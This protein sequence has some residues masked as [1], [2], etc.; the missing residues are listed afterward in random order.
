VDVNSCVNITSGGTYDLNGSLSGAPNDASE[1]TGVSNACIKIAANSV[2]LDCHGY[3]ISLGGTDSV[4]I[5]IN[6]SRSGIT[7]RN[8][9]NITGFEVGIQAEDVD[10]STFYNNVISS[11]SVYGV[12][13]LYGNN[14]NF[15]LNTLDNTGLVGFGL[16]NVSNSHIEDNVVTDSGHGFSVSTVTG[17][18]FTGNNVSTDGNGFFIGIDSDGNTFSFNRIFGGGNSG[19]VIVTS[20]TGNTFTS[21]DVIGNTNWG[22]TAGSQSSGNT[23]IDNYVFNNGLE[24][25]SMTGSSGGNTFIVNNITSNDEDGME[26]RSGSGS[27]DFLVNYIYGNGGDGVDLGS[28][29]NNSFT[30]DTSARNAAN[31][32]RLDGSTGNTFIVTYAYNN[33]QDGYNLMDSPTN[34]FVSVDAVDNTDDGFEASASDNLY[35]SGTFCGNGYRGVRVF[36]SSSASVLGATVCN[37]TSNDGI[38]FARVNDSMVDGNTVYGNVNG[39]YLSGSSRNITVEDSTVRDNS[40]NGIQISGSWGNTIMNNLVHGN[41]FR[42]IEVSMSTSVDNVFGNNT[43]YENRYGF[44]LDSDNQTLYDNTVFNNS[45]D[46]IFLFDSNGTTLTNEHLYNNNVDLLLEADGGSPFDLILTGVVFDWPVGNFTN[47]TNVSVTDTLAS[48]ESYSLDWAMQPATPLLAGLQSFEGKFIQITN[49]TPM[50]VDSM[51]WHWSDAE[52]AAYSEGQFRLVSHFNNTWEY[53]P[54][55]PDTAANTLTFLNMTMPYLMGIMQA[56]GSDDDNGGGGEDNMNVEFEPSC[57]GNVVSVEDGSPLQDADVLV[58]DTDTLQIVASGKSNSSGEF[59]FDGCGMDVK[60]AVQKSGYAKAELFE[61]LPECSECLVAECITDVDCL[62]NESCVAGSCVPVPCECGEVLNHQ[63]SPYECCADENCEDGQCV[64]NTC[65]AA[66]VPEEAGCLTDGDCS[67]TESCSDGQC[68][69]VTGQCGYAE[70]H[71][72]VSYE[73]GEG[74]PDCAEGYSCTGNECVPEEEPPAVN[75]TAEDTEELAGDADEEQAEPGLFDG[76]IGW[77]FLIIIAIIV[78]AGIVYYRRSR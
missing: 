76:M 58:W 3:D 45:I 34:D 18:T 31:G 44:E 6:G 52:A 69:Q 48:G 10:G 53:M 11:C 63:C 64:N 75:D 39:I 71:A 5:A 60:I 24:G 7:V 35:I 13:I 57:D 32:F 12:R 68:A 49:Y 62:S 17:S 66:E 14:N 51:V 78:V 30:F 22:F 38:A 40:N 9:D 37:H 61:S 74:C 67:G 33:T 55:N 77:L 43:V 65:E 4:A 21:N 42:G 19:F 20:S 50:A 41:N 16:T 28:T 2:T 29:E 36:N 25:F 54:P 56:M 8:C 15:T 27:N 59:S 1:M 26:F 73:C 70:D 72:W 47:Y 46:G 23:Y